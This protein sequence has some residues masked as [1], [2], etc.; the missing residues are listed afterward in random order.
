MQLFAGLVIFKKSPHRCKLYPIRNG[1]GLS[2][3]QKTCASFPVSWSEFMSFS[4][5]DVFFLFV[6]L[7][8]FRLKTAKVWCV[9]HLFGRLCV[10][11]GER[12]RKTEM[13][14]C[15]AARVNPCYLAV[16]QSNQQDYVCARA[17]VR[18]SL[19]VCVSVWFLGWGDWG[20]FAFAPV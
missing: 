12:L 4:L 9:E 1:W 7:V 14:K 16:L 18:V 13:W 5:M 11:G 19:W 20:I 2:A 10:D 17:R 15:I 6:F 3:I 8:A